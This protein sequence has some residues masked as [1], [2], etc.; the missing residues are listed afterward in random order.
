M[1]SAL[2]TITLMGTSIRDCSRRWAVTTTSSRT[3]SKPSSSS[4]WANTVKL[5]E[6][7]RVEKQVEKI[8]VPRLIGF[9]PEFAK[10]IYY[11]CVKGD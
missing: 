1:V 8:S 11:T 10:P 2:N 4:V 6:S 3:P 5:E 7:K 9:S